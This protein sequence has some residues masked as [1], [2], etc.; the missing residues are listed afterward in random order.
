MHV[1]FPKIQY[2]FKIRAFELIDVIL[3]S[4][5]DAKSDPFDMYSCPCSVDVKNTFLRSSAPCHSEMERK[6]V[7]ANRTISFFP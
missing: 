3:W 7:L 2:V 5:G 6:H 1:R 4:Y